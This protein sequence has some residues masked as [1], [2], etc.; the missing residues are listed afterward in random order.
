MKTKF[1][2][3]DEFF[4]HLLNNF[5][6]GIV[7]I[8]SDYEITYVSDLLSRLTEYSK[9][10]LVGKLAEDIFPED[11]Y[12][13]RKIFAAG[14]VT[15]SIKFYKKFKCKT[16]RQFVARIRLTTGKDSKGDLRFVVYVKDNTAYERTQN[17]IL[18]KALT[19]EHLAKSRKIRNG[20]LEKA[21]TEI[22][23]STARSMNT[24]RINAWV[25]SE[26]QSKINCI[27]NF[28]DGAKKMLEEETLSRLNMPNYFKLFETEKL[29]ISTDALNDPNTAELVDIYLKPHNIYSLMD[30][31]IRI[32][33]DLIGVLCFEHTGTPRAWNKQEQHFGLVVAQMISL[34]LETLHRQKAT[35]DLKEALSG[36]KVLL[37]E[38]QHRVKNNL[39]I[40]SSLINLQGEKTKDEFHK[41]LFQESKNR[42]DSIARVHE[43]LY[44]SESY[45]KVNLKHYLEEILDNLKD[46]FSGNN[47]KIQIMDEVED[48][49]LDVSTG[50]PLGL[51]LNELV[52][53]CYKHAFNNADTGVIEVKLNEEGKKIKLVVKDN[54]SGFDPANAGKS[55]LG[56]HILDGLVEQISGELKYSNNNSGTTAAISFERA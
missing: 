31:P 19:I 10:D 28:D 11:V 40:I 25:F 36:Q 50:I 7:V 12:A 18:R 22:L 15:S 51:I 30:I 44:R 26:D 49:T 23:Q 14:E 2:I 34:A 3:Q 39:A 47:K 32:E 1:E 6:E 52:T 37:K 9:E 13:L 27:G 56:L 5:S 29:I 41:G 33:G 43:L 48:I 24:Q 20:E 55:S 45:T 38:V 21:I 54:G 8:N 17:D 4:E 35:S 53:N 16:G 46:S 42:L